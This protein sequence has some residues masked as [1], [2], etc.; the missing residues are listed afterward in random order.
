M[1]G[2]RGPRSNQKQSSQP[3]DSGNRELVVL[4][5]ADVGLRVSG[6]EVASALGADTS[7]LTKILE[8]EKAFIK[9]MFGDEEQ[10]ETELASAPMPEPGEP[11][12]AQFYN[13]EA[14]DDKLDDLAKKLLESPLVESAYVKPPAE[15]AVIAEAEDVL[16]DTDL[17]E[18]INDMEPAL[19]APPAS[20]NFTARQGY[21][22]TAPVGVDARYAWR[23]PG[24]RGSN[25]RVIDLEWGWNF[26]HEDLRQNQGGVIAGRN[27][28]NNDHGT[29]VIGVIGGDRNNFGVTG[30][31]PDAVVSA[32]SFTT[33]NLSLIHI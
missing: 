9:P 5:K 7:S 28:S 1:A 15:L 10:L 4:T 30:I 6:D 13:V 17:N 18:A 8:G 3:S 25:V 22:N 31:S 27:S 21:L 16:D 14:D 29:A 23:F 32:V 24:G 33:I 26:T 11:H 12:L 2:K 20:P 19:E